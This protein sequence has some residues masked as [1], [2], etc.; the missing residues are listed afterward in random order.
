MNDP[1]GF[2]RN[3]VFRQQGPHLLLI[4]DQRGRLGRRDAVFDIQ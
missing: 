4:A 3:A 2:S 1:D